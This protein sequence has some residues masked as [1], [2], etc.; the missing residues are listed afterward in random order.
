MKVLI[1]F[2]DSSTKEIYLPIFK[3]SNLNSLVSNLDPTVESFIS[4]ETYDYTKKISDHF[5]IDVSEVKSI[6]VLK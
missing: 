2:N 3:N 5:R 4:F 6:K 1:N